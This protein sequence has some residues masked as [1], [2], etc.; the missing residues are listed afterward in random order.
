M[1]LRLLRLMLH[2]VARILNPG[3]DRLGPFLL[4]AVVKYLPNLLDIQISHV[5]TL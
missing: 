4:Q 2:Q 3:S 5:F 1:T